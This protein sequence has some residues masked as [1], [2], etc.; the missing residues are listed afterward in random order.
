MV[1]AETTCPRCNIK[2][3]K[4]TI[5][6]YPNISCSKCGFQYFYTTL[7][8][9]ARKYQWHTKIG[10]NVYFVVWLKYNFTYY[11]YNCA[12]HCLEDKFYVKFEEW[13]PFDI[14]L[15][16]ELIKMYLTFQ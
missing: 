15:T 1:D 5:N 14:E 11:D 10:D 9:T 16:P 13:L 7:N 4:E 12:I 2:Y 8:G 6:P 3:C